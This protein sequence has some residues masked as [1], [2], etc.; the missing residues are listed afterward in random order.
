MKFDKIRY[1]HYDFA[2]EMIVEDIKYEKVS[3]MEK[4]IN[5][6][7]IKEINVE[8]HFLYSN[9]DF[10][11]SSFIGRE[12]KIKESKFKRNH[13]KKNSSKERLIEDKGANNDKKINN[14]VDNAKEL[15]NKIKESLN[16]EDKQRSIE[17]FFLI[18]VLIL[19][20][21]LAIGIVVNY[22]IITQINDDASNIHLICYSAELRTYY[23]LAVYYL[24]E[25]TLVNFLVPKYSI[26]ENYTQYPEYVG[27][28][29]AYIE[30]LRSKIQNIYIETHVLT[31]FLTSVS[32]PL[33]ENT[34]FFLQ[35]DNLTLFVLANNL[36]FYKITTTFSISLIEINS[37]LYNLAI[38][39]TFIQQNVTDVFIFIYN[40]LNEVGNGIKD[41]IDIYINELELRFD[42]KQKILI[43]GLVL[44]F[45][46]IVIIIIIL[47]IS[48]RSIIKKKSSYIEGFYGIKIPF[49]RQ[50]IRNCEHFI[51]FLKKQKRED[52][53]GLKHDKNS[54]ISQNNGEFEKEYEEEMK[55]YDNS[56]SINKSLNDE[57]Y[58]YQRKSTFTHNNNRD[59]SSII[60]FAIIILIYFAIIFA[61]FI[62][63]FV[64]YNNF[65]KDVSR[66][67]KFI[68]H[69]Q[70]IQNNIID[71]FNGYREFIFDKNSI[72]NGHKSE[73]YLQLK[74]EDIFATKG[75]DTFIVNSTYRYIKNFKRSFEKF[76]SDSLCSR[77]DDNYFKS[78]EECLNYLEGQIKYG[79]QITSFA[80]I[81]FIKIGINMI[82]YYFE[83]E[84][85]IAGNLTEYGIDEYKD[86]NENQTFRLFLFNNETTHSK[87]NILFV[88]T[89]LPFYSNIINITSNAIIGDSSNADSLFLL[90]MICFISINTVLFLIVWIPFIKNMNSIIYNAKKILGIIPIHILST[91][92]NIKKILNMEKVKNG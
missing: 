70:R 88:H 91:L 37:A 66:N 24:R 41:Q 10:N 76:N 47:C 56:Y 69:L 84:M 23:N 7:K 32:I 52:D 73:D 34:T 4:E 21:L 50:S 58:N 1:F 54:E 49:I 59:S 40:Y 35:E 25:L 55:M 74:L 36:E 2:R 62:I 72:I 67:S 46:L 18:S 5:E 31:E 14:L 57:Y 12:S 65:M 61:F 43:I 87:L 9:K 27:D 6:C 48:Y 92:S 15:E 90:Y 53:S 75:N 51:Y 77:T 79:Y 38:S 26:L 19:L 86:I 20:V 33:S 30:F 29:L 82:N 28:R 13:S 8:S 16:Q 78:E 11:F 3:K 64:T 83:K 71:F 85:D 89:L 22:Y 39:D 44:I 63:V 60:F 80:L 45:I 68:F 81:E 42:N 17:I